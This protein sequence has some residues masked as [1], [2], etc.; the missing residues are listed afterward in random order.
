MI[1]SAHF[2]ISQLIDMLWVLKRTVSARRFFW[3]P[4]QMFKMTAEEDIHNF[5]FLNPGP[6]PGR[7]ISF[8]FAL[9]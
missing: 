4:K 6:I 5:T 8:C 2:P 9:L 3:A 1:K 7:R